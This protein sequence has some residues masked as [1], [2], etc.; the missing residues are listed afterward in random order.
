MVGSCLL[1]WLWDGDEF[2]GRSNLGPGSRD[3]IAS[4]ARAA[5]RL[6]APAFIGRTRQGTRTRL[7][8]LL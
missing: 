8:A 1:I 4:G 3:G 5:V 7:L 2:L 6:L